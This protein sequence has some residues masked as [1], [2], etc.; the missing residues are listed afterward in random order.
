MK[1]TFSRNAL[2]CALL[3]CSNTI[4]AQ[5]I[6]HTPQDEPNELETI[7]VVSSKI[8]TPLRE[9]AT[10]VTVISKED[11]EARAN[12]S[13]SEIM[14]HEVSVGVSNSGGIGKNTTL[15]IRGEDGFR[16]KVFMDGIE[17]SDPTA[18]QATPI[19]DDILSNFVER[20]EILRGP[21]GLMY[22]ADAGGVVSITTEQASLGLHGSAKAE[23]GSDS[24]QLINGEL[25]FANDTGHIYLAAS[26][27]ST[28]GFNA[29]T[30]DTSNEKDGYENT[31]IHLN[32]GLNLS[33]DL[34]LNFVL[35]D[36][37][38]DNDYDGCYDN[39][40]YAL[41]NQCRTEGEN[42]TAR[43]SVHY[44]QKEMG[45]T[46]GL[47]K[48]DIERDFF[49]NE[50]F[51]YGSKGEIT[52]VDYTGFYDLKRHK[53][54]WGADN[55]SQKITSSKLEREQTGVY[56]EYQTSLQDSLYFT[57]GMRYDDN[58]TFGT[59]TSYRVSAAYLIPLAKQNTL[60]FKSTYGTG[61]RAPS[62]YEQDYN[63]GDYAYGDAAGLQLKEETSKGFDFGLEFN[64]PNQHASLV[65]FKQTIA[66][67]IYF[68]NI[69][70]QG[71]LQN[72]SSSESQG[73]ELEFSQDLTKQLRLRANY[74]YNET[75]TTDEQPR[76]R[77]PKQQA[78]IGLQQSWLA[79]S[80][81]TNLFVNHVR[82][83][84]DIGGQPLDNYSVVSVSANYQ[85][86]Q[87]LKFNVKIDNLLDRE[88]QEVAG[89]NTS[90]LAV[91]IGIQA[92][93]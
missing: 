60:K 93:L 50:Q 5:T 66:D 70:Y 41:I 74:T 15:R 90:G 29:Q 88:Y 55:E 83:L 47:A 63:N 2:C 78:N 75:H 18:P 1:P 92:S 13:L 20:I 42:Q 12:T 51:S 81:Q 11:I 32:A 22:G 25:G 19:F 16:T 28:D 43:L 79:Q 62:L 89:Y 91:Y 73:A 86:N 26:D 64:N 9:I 45:H 40:T 34:Q 39:I 6:A 4:N 14:R 56:V 21:Q 33:Q 85:L 87:A 65:F 82:E 7:T 17:L 61:F 31:T 54:I 8:A 84:F 49:S 67:E 36:V 44:Q 53:L 30:S 69:A 57:A 24:T 37:T 52:K 76:L 35:R 10:S 71:Y 58:D 23:L 68:D 27:F 38:S 77:R 3:F 48:T 72:A 59:H 80:L 46:L